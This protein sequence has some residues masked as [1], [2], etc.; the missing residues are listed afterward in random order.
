MVAY[1]VKLFTCCSR[2]SLVG[3]TVFRSLCNAG[4]Q[5]VYGLGQR[6]NHCSHK[7]ALFK[8]YCTFFVYHLIKG[9]PWACLHCW[10]QRGA[11]HPGRVLHAERWVWERDQE[12]WKA[13]A[14]R[15]PAHRCSCHHS[16]SGYFTCFSP[17]VLCD[18]TGVD[19][20]SYFQPL[21]TFTTLPAG[22]NP[23]PVEN[24]LLESSIQVVTSLFHWLLLN[25]CFA[26]TSMPLQDTSVSSRILS[27]Q[28]LSRTFMCLSSWPPLISC[29]S[30]LNKICD[31]FR[32]MSKF[33]LSIQRVHGT[34]VFCLGKQV[35]RSGLV[36]KTFET[37]ILW[38]GKYWVNSM[39][40]KV[41]EWSREEPWQNLQAII[42]ASIW[43]LLLAAKILQIR[44]NP[45]IEIQIWASFL[46][47]YPPYTWVQ[48]IMGLL[49]EVHTIAWT[50]ITYLCY[51]LHSGQRYT[52]LIIIQW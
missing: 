38:M 40:L 10:V 4:F 15:V 43:S 32:T 26:R 46:T 23:F 14:S 24:R 44:L 36:L 48:G 8:Y 16:A 27:S 49:V 17:C 18:Y 42:Q 33:L 47:M 6:Q 37:Y 13:F 2:N 20:K 39:I 28:S 22:K 25:P 51:T 35:Q 34:F 3:E 7:G 12:D 30:G 52:M 9:C 29:L 1:Q 41:I 11:V 19:Y 50:S 21:Q 31:M 5:P 45:P